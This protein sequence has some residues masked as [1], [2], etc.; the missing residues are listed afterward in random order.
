MPKPMNTP[1][2]KSRFHALLRKAAQP[3]QKEEGQPSQEVSETLESRR[4]DD[5]SETHT[6]P[7]KTE[8]SED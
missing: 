7:S 6:N 3:I 2:T 8:G 5:C 1:L 4:P